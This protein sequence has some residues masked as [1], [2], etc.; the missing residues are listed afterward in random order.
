[1]NASMYTCIPKIWPQHYMIDEDEVETYLPQ[2][3]QALRKNGMNI[4]TI[5]TCI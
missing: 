5:Y 4:I 1:M 2:I 3:S